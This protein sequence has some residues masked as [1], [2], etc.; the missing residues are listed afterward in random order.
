MHV[1]AVW[2]SPHHSALALGRVVCESQACRADLEAGRAQ[3]P[4]RER[5]RG[6][7]WL[8]DG[9][10]VRL[11]PAHKDHVWS[12]DFVQ[13]RTHDGRS[14]RMLVIVGPTR[15]C[16]AIGVARSRK[17][18]DVPERLAWLMATRGVPGHV[19]SDNRAECTA[20]AVRAWPRCEWCELLLSRRLRLHPRSFATACDSLR[21]QYAPA[22]AECLRRC[23]GV[24]SA[25]ALTAACSAARVHTAA[26]SSWTPCAKT[27]RDPPMRSSAWWRSSARTGRF[28]CSGWAIHRSTRRMPRLNLRQSLH[29]TCVAY[30]FSLTGS[31]RTTARGRTRSH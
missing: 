8:N 11:R 1:R 27:T 10:C 2:I 24:A 9:S 18:D 4:Q 7:L 20:K 5:K 12:Y 16:V 23:S 21:P 15:E 14:F 28:G 13:A 25:A 19:R 29:A 6:R 22:D 17:S 31:P 30:G 26:L 3:R